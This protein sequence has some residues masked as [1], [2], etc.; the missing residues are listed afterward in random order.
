[1]GKK[2]MDH[3]GREY[4]SLNEMLKAYNVNRTTYYTRRKAGW[5]L[6]KILEGGIHHGKECTDHLGNKYPSCAAMCKS[7]GITPNLF[8]SRM[9]MYRDNWGAWTLE[10]ALCGR[11]GKEC[12]EGE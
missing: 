12:N 3:F 2:C 4:D 1:M 6:E 8:Y 11:K 9:K 7:Y 5:P 10:E